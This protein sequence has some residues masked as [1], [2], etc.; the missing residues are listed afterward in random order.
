[1]KK[2]RMQWL[3]LAG[4]AVFGAAGGIYLFRPEPLK[5]ESALV[6]CGPMAVTISSEGRTRV[7]DRFVVSS[8]VHGNLGRLEA[9]EGHRIKRGAILTWV[10]PAPLE[11]R[12]ERQG[13][14][15]LQAAEMERQSAEAIAAGARVDLEQATRELQRISKLVE[16]GIRPRQELE[17]AEAAE[18]GA[19]DALG[20]ATAAVGAAD[21]HIEEIR[22]TLLSGAAHAIPIRSPVEGLVLRVIQQSERILPAGTPVA[23]IGD[24]R[25]LEL[26]F[27]ILSSDAVRVPA[28][29]DVI[30]QNWAADETLTARVRLVEPGAFTKVSALG[31]EEQRVNVVADLVA[32]STLLGDGYRV[33]GE[34]VVWRSDNSIQ[35]PVSALFRHGSEWQVFVVENGRIVLRT[36]RIGHRNQ[37][38]AEV[39]NGLVEGEEVV[40]YPDD[41]LEAGLPVKGVVKD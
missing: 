38:T 30:L 36:I 11:I 27:E 22:S 7:R 6:D 12:S 40:L 10:T 28:G 19:R 5:I 26:V 41:R 37:K 2:K 1:M 15:S 29:A 32:A 25:N 4:L 24:A 3:V 17:T 34:I 13:E 33:E 14:A 9:K 23:E 16:H 39:L 18:S 35:V 31:V 20:A 8:P 21:F